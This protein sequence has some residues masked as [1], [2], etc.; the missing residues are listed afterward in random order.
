ML[1]PKQADSEDFT[2]TVQRPWQWTDLTYTF[3]VK[4]K[5][6]DISAIRIDPSGR[7]ADVIPD[8]DVG[9][10]APKGRGQSKGRVKDE[11]RP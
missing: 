9:E 8:N 1:R 6:K 5:L 10:A 4:G 3:S 7:M 11:K 2:F